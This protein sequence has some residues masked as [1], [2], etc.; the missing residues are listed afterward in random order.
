MPLT[1]LKWQRVIGNKD[2]YDCSNLEFPFIQAICSIDIV[3]SQRDLCLI[4]V[5]E[6]VQNLVLL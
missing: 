3:Q 4:L 5:S 1:R 2:V 6:E